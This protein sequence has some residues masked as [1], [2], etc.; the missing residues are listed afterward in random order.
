MKNSWADSLDKID[1]I[2][3]T[4]LYREMDVLQYLNLKGIQYFPAQGTWI[5][6]KCLLPEHDDATPSFYI[7]T[8]TLGYNC[9]GCKRHGNFYELCKTLGWDIAEGDNNLIG[10]VAQSQWRNFKDNIASDEI[11]SLVR[12]RLPKGF[13]FVSENDNACKKHLEYAID[14]GLDDAIKIFKI[15][16][17]VEYDSTYYKM[18]NNRLLIPVYDPYGKVVWIEGRRIDGI[19]TKKYWRP[20]GVKK[21]R[22][23]FNIHRLLL[24]EFR[25]AIVV[26]GIIDAILLWIW[27]FPAVCIFGS[28]I[29]LEQSNQLMYFDALYLCFDNDE[30]G[31][32]G[33]KAASKLFVGLGSELYHIP[34]PTGKDAADIGK[35]KF[36]KR[37]QRARKI[38]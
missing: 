15:G 31:R 1:T 24:K 22:I 25:W 34:M 18:Y 29:S 27:G 11:I 5:K 8:A 38:Y 32:I 35:E 10:L 36:T 26:E 19:K 4:D 28:S 6:M 9:Y 12:H 16:Y 3:T 33:Y 14:R 13:T 23:V 21:D 20:S 30:A 2:R 37:L 17:T 7:N